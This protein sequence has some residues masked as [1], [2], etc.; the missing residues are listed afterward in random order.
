MGEEQR[1]RERAALEELASKS[2]L[3]IANRAAVMCV[4]IINLIICVAYI[5]EVVG[6]IADSNFVVLLSS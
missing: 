5:I 1:D 2:E 3:A 6:V 4:T